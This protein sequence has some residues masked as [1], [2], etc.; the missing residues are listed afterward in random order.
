M[1]KPKRTK[2]RLSPVYGPWRVTPVPRSPADS[3]GSVDWHG[4]G[5]NTGAGD[6]AGCGHR[7]LTIFLGMLFGWGYETIGSF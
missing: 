1:K 3:A 4:A 5:D 7:K 6:L 2:F